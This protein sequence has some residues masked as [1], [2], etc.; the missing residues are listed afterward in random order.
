VPL[1]DAYF[2]LVAVVDD[3]EAAQ[4]TFGNWVAPAASARGTLPRLGRP[5]HDLD[6]G[7]RRLGLEVAAG[8]RATRGGRLLEWRTA[9]LAGRG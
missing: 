2:E 8:S 5:H 6:Q 9:G 3:A 4:G 1:G 7:A